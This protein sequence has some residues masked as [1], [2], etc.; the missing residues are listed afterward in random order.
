MRNT[1]YNDYFCPELKDVFN[2]IRSGI[3]GD[4][5]EFDE[6]LN[7]I[8]NNNDFYLVGTDFGHYRETQERS[9]RVFLDKQKWNEMSIRCAIRMKKFSSDRTIMEYAQNIW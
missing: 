3:L 1:Q 9:E 5:H 2:E 6:L 7:T 8:T 4:P